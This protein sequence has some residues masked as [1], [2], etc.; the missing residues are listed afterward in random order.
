MPSKRHENLP[1][2]FW[3]KIFHDFGRVNCEIATFP[4]Y[5]HLSF[6]SRACQNC[7]SGNINHCANSK[8]V[9]ADGVKRGYLSINFQL[10]APAIHVCKNDVIVV[11][12][13]ND[14]AGTATRFLVHLRNLKF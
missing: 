10:P 9:M 6:H 2:L 8:C 4:T 5:Q 1:L 14:A 11:D 3:T 12:L 13:A 7:T